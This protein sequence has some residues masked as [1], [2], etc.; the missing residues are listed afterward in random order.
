MFNQ[1]KAEQQ[2]S[3]RT[4]SYTI[5]GGNTLNGSVNVPGAKNAA[6]PAIIAASLSNETVRLTNIPLELNDTIL[7]LELLESIGIIVEKVDSTTVDINGSGTRDG[8]LDGDKASKIRHS[9]L[10]L[11]LSAAK[12]KSLFLPIPGGC[13]IGSRKHDLHIMALGRIGHDIKESDKGLNLI[14]NTNNN[15]PKF[16]TID[17]HYPTF[18]GTFNAIFASVLMEERNVI[19]RNP[20]KNPEVV[21]V[22]NMMVQMGANI[23]WDESENLVIKGV[24]SLKGI[25]HQVMSDRIIAA[26]IIAAIG[27]TQGEG[28]IKGAD[29]KYLKTE[30]DT[31]KR[32]GLTIKS[33]EEGVYVKGNKKIESV[34]VETNAYPA[35]HTDIQPL[36]GVLMS[37]SK[38]TS[39]I[40][41]VILD[42]RF[43][44][45]YEL[46][47]MG[48]N[49]EVKDGSFTCVNGA[50]GQ[51]AYFNSPSYFVGSLELVATDIRGGAAVVIGA[52]IAK[53]ES[54]ISNIYQIE[55]G[56][57]NLPE[58]LNEL[59]ADIKRNY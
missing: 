1:S 57:T 19:I 52:L 40:K 42:G 26:T 35:F 54:Q 31:W 56:Y 12:G 17:F 43:K 2:I 41:D 21:D 51:V 7:L 10:I 27:A 45:C 9:L 29:P 46:N 24:K 37:I 28:I 34:D 15:S 23:K 30:I 11:G 5:R 4:V 55:R 22:V 48:A 36:H 47:K 59:G 14:S 39:S 32:S 13:S 3:R 18:G 8:I 53:G 6:L 20:A 25:T 33:V 58:M 38:D 16:M 50:P 44:Y 49:I